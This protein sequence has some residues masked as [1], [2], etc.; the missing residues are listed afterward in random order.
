[1]FYLAP[2]TLVI[3]PAEVPGSKE[4]SNTEEHLEWPG[5]VVHRLDPLEEGGD[6]PL[7]VTRDEDFEGH[8]DFD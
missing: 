4:G 7:G 3:C 6:V 1:M 5:L 2:P 8:C